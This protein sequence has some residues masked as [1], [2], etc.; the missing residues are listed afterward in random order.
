MKN[1]YDLPYIPKEEYEIIKNSLKGILSSN[2]YIDKYV[3]DEEGKYFLVKID[4]IHSTVYEN[5]CMGYAILQK[6]A[7]V[8]ICLPIKIVYDIFKHLL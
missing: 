3:T 1:N 8:G 6:E 4:C 2:S 5:L 7:G